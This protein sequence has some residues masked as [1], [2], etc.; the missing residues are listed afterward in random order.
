MVTAKPKSYR[1]LV[2]INYPPA[3]RAEPD[4]I[5]DDLPVGSI[6]WL[7]E[8]GHIEPTAPKKET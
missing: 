1:V 7:T 6:P 3:R 4:D 2:G 5:V 8:Q